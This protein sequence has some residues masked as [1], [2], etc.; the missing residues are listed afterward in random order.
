MCI[1]WIEFSCNF[2][3]SDRRRISSKLARNGPGI[4]SIGLRASSPEGLAWLVWG[5]QTSGLIGKSVSSRVRAAGPGISL[6]RAEGGLDA[7][8]PLTLRWDSVH[9]DSAT[10]AKADWCAVFLVPVDSATE[11][12]DP[13]YPGDQ[14]PDNM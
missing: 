1:S 7:M 8:P 3:G 6:I 10:Q 14:D 2:A 5:L 9:G 13:E 11:C 4:L 12:V